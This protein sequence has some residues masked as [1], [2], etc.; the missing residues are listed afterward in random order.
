MFEK[1]QSITGLSAIPFPSG[2][3]GQGYHDTPLCLTDLPTVLTSSPPTLD[4]YKGTFE[5]KIHIGRMTRRA[6][7][8]PA[9]Q[10]PT[11]SNLYGAMCLAT[12]L[13][14]LEQDHFGRICHR[15]VRV[16]LAIAA[17]SYRF[18]GVMIAPVQRIADNP[19]AGVNLK[20]RKTKP[21]PTPSTRCID[22]FPAANPKVA[23]TGSLS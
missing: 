18:L 3:S 5:Y 13:Q 11:T 10:S 1:R 4:K 19:C 7:T 14:E 8:I 2:Q 15:V 23:P 22:Q 12:F 20:V 17:D 16:L 9:D 21:S 6:I